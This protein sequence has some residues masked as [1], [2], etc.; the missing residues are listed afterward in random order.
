MRMGDMSANMVVVSYWVERGPRH[1]FRL[2]KQLFGYE[3]GASFSLTLVCNGGD[4]KPIGLAGRFAGLGI[5]VLNR[6]NRGFN[7]GAWDCGWRSTQGYENFLFLQDDCFVVRRGWLRGFLNAMSR[8][9]D[10]G[11]LGESFRRSWDRPWEE[12]KRLGHNSFAKGHDVAGRSMRRVDL[13]LDFL[14][15]H[16]IPPG[17][18]ARH[19]QSLVL[20]APRRVL[21]E[22][23][24]FPLGE[25]YGEAIASEIAIS[26]KVESKGYRTALVGPRPFYYFGHRGWPRNRLQRLRRKLIRWWRRKARGFENVYRT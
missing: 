25:S 11:L 24:G 19:L 6:E 21:A 20:F 17:E 8:E 3:A 22:M 15:R 26:K 14:D 5:K 2:M 23:G 1:L 7:I 9:P 4:E 13:Y 16:S 12:L 10:I 18:S